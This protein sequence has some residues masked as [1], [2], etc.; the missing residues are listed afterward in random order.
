MKM[1]RLFPALGHG[2]GLRPKH[3]GRFLE[4]NPRVDWVEA[5]TENYLSQGGRPLA[6]LEKARRDRPVV[7]HGVSLSIGSVDPLNED[8]LKRV[9]ALAS[10]IEPAWI[11]D[12]LCW[13]SHGRRYA[14]DLLP[15]PWT[16][17]SLAHVSARV[18]RVQ[19]ALGRRILLENVSS[20]VAFRDSTMTEWEFLARV[21]E[22]A[23]CGILLDVNNVYVSARNHGFDAD[24]YL[25]ALPANRIGQFHLAGHADKGK[26]LLDTHDA[27]VPESVWSLYA[28]AV[29][30]FG[31]VPAL[32]EWDDQ[33][34]ELEELLAQS[35]RAAEIEARVL[36]E[37]LPRSA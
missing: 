15:L 14:H 9:R 18:R 8:Y 11:S 21:A 27:P 1:Q 16:E 13:G 33:I 2:V 23:D 6:A 26:Y 32:I 25:A 28:T 24:T 20:Y 19:D 3:Y 30:R 7:L 36:S 34:P 5:I 4:G 37:S 31:A 35:R 12:H 29:R 10:R 22:D 17:E